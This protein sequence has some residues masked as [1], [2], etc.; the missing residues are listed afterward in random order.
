MNAV[1]TVMIAVVG[2]A[3]IAASFLTK[4]SAARGTPARA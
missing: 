4:L 2:V 1:C 3:V